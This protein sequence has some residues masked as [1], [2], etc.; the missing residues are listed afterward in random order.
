MGNNFMAT[1]MPATVVMSNTTKTQLF[2]LG[3]VYVYSSR[4]LNTSASSETFDVFVSNGNQY[5]QKPGRLMS[6]F[7]RLYDAMRR[8]NDLIGLSPIDKFKASFVPG[9]YGRVKVG[10]GHNGGSMAG[11]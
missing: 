3:N 6:T 4:R 11:G 9:A 8:Y 7:S 1:N 2:N 10:P 5:P